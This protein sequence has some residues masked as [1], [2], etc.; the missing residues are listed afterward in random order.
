MAEMNPNSE[1]IDRE[2]D[3][4]G[5]IMFNRVEKYL[6]GEG[7]EIDP[8]IAFEPASLTEGASPYC[9]FI[10]EHQLPIEDRICLILS[11]VPLLKPQL[12]DCLCIRNSDTGRPFVEFGCRESKDGRS[13]RPTL[14]TLLFILAGDDTPKRLSYAA[15]FVADPFLRANCF[16][17]DEDSSLDKL[18]SLTLS[19]SEELVETLLFDR[20]FLPRHSSTFPATQMVTER[21]WEDLVLD[22]N[23]AEQVDEIRLWVK[24][25]Q[26]VRQEWNLAH[27]LR[28]GYRALFYGP[29]GC[30]KTF[31]ASLLGQVTGKDVY[32]IDLSSV[33]SKYIGETEKNLDRIFS[34]AEGKEWILFF[35]EA[36]SL[37]GKRTGIK[38][39]HD[40][41][42]NQEVS[43]LLQR[44]EDYPGLVILST[45]QKVNID[46]AFARRFQSVIKFTMPD[47]AQRKKLWLSAF[48]ECTVFDS[49][50]NWDDISRKYELSGGSIM[51]IVQY[52]SV[53]AMSRGENLIRQEDV[54]VGIRR[55]FSK[56]GKVA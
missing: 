30:G 35:D 6:K 16:D 22:E 36:D 45:N 27:K 21:R 38:D 55:E 3:W 54:L 5:N 48:S 44:V 43:Y 53:M 33:V 47:A 10:S 18:T 23:T 7:L 34:M 9:R 50:L 37:F 2:L 42:A 11:F 56:E 52:A 39:S 41:Y 31:T 26:R 4:L 25:G 40:R 8:V 51:N 17:T 24:F 32:R 1:F 28:P 29:P 13:L 19:P 20:P 15:H 46:D 14:E 12:L 49:Q